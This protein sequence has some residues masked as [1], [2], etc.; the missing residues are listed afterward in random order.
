M[1]K[2]ECVAKRAWKVATE[3]RNRAGLR[4]SAESTNLFDLENGECAGFNAAY[5]PGSGPN[6]GAVTGTTPD[7][8]RRA[9]TRR[10]SPVPLPPAATSQ[11][12]SSPART[13]RFGAC[14]AHDSTL[15]FDAKQG[16]GRSCFEGVPR[17]TAPAVIF[18]L[19]AVTARDSRG[20]L[21]YVLEWKTKPVRR[22]PSTM[23]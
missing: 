12:T 1:F 6:S 8:D 15:D 21:L 20:G 9:C 11:G 13:H 23:H 14:L 16:A 5:R 18:C 17:R 4:S 19:L 7:S 3:D 2:T 10:C 22:P